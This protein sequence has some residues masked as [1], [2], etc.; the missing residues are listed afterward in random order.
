MPSGQIN[1]SYLYIFF[2][3]HFLYIFGIIVLSDHW[4]SEDV[5]IFSLKNFDCFQ[6][7]G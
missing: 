5:S 7:E 1:F 4:Y 3:S 6:E 2:G